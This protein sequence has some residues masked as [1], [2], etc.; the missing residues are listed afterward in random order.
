MSDGGL[1]VLIMGL[2]AVTTGCRQN[3]AADVSAALLDPN[4]EVWSAHAPDVFRASFETTEGTFVIQARR[5]WAPH[6]VDRF[7]HLVQTGFFDDSRFYRVR[8]GFIAQFGIP[9]DPVVAAV[10]REETIPD[11]SVRQSNTRGFVAFAMTGPD[12]RTTQLYVNYG[13]NSRLDADGFAP[14][15]RVIEGMEVVDRLYADYDEDA[16]GGM[17]GGMQGKIFEGGNAHLDQAFPNLDR[18]IRASIVGR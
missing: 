5:E 9:G 8:A 16:G 13:D 3:D 17:R 6:G 14:I 4:H 15:G 18:L 1:A 7:Y 2:V 11:D 12:T 10:W